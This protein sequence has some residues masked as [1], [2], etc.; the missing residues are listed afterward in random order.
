MEITNTT[1]HISAVPTLESQLSLKV[2]VSYS[3]LRL[4]DRHPNTYLSRAPFTPLPLH[5]SNC[6]PRDLGHSPFAQNRQPSCIHELR[7][8]GE[9][10]AAP[11]RAF[12]TVLV[13]R[14]PEP[15][16]VREAIF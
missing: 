13:G 3:P 5:L 12:I 14:L 16:A 8:P 9:A 1:L 11:G 7:E 6:L 4:E 15:L 2:H 10:I